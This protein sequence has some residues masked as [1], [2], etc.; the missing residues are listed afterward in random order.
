MISN[1]M[2]RSGPERIVH[3]NIL[4]GENTRRGVISLKKVKDYN[5]DANDETDY[6]YLIL[7]SML[8]LSITIIISITISIVKVGE[9]N[10]AT[11]K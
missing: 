11:T 4:I 6:N 8:S 3:D 7:A 9:V 10:V 2:L 5:D 1:V